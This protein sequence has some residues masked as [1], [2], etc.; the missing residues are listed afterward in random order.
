VEVA[1]SSSSTGDQTQ[2]SW[3]PMMAGDARLPA[4]QLAKCRPRQLAK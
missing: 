4:R 2:S 3:P 1:W